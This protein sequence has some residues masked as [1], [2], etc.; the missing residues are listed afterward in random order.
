MNHN[1]SSE[2]DAESETVE[3]NCC[4]NP[5]GFLDSIFSVQ[6]LRILI[7]CFHIASVVCDII[8]VTSNNTSDDGKSSVLTTMI[9][10]SIGVCYCLTW[11]FI[12]VVLGKK[13]S[14][15]KF[16]CDEDFSVTCSDW[17]TDMIMI[18]VMVITFSLSTRFACL[19]GNQTRSICTLQTVGLISNSFALISYLVLV[20]IGIT[21]SLCRPFHRQ[22]LKATKQQ[23]HVLP[24]FRTP[25]SPSQTVYNHHSTSPSPA[26]DISLVVSKVGSVV[27]KTFTFVG[28]KISSVSSTSSSSSAPPS[29]IPTAPKSDDPQKPNLPPRDPSPPSYY[30]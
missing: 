15:I 17:A 24:I 25:T 26:G 12:N 3:I 18:C 14:S 27:G 2:Q 20:A 22:P 19:A 7:L 29:I 21:R 11:L 6:F 13:K 23:Q 8:V 4:C 30:Q 9:L 28:Q 1:N 5:C 16:R 10:S